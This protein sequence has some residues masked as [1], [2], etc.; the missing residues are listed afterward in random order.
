MT[1]F[2]ELLNEWLSYMEVQ[3]KP[4]TY[5]CYLR[6]AKI[7]IEPYFSHIPAEQ[8]NQS[9]VAAFISE[10]LE[11]GRSD[12]Q[13]GLSEKTVKDIMSVINSVCKYG[14][15]VYGVK[16]QPL[17][18]WRYSNISKPIQVFT[19]EEQK[20]LEDFLT[21]NITPHKLGILICLYTGMRLGE[22]CALSW[23]NV[24]LERKVFH[25]EKT[26][27]RIYTKEMNGTHIII[28]LPKSRAAIRE[29]P[30]ASCLWQYLANPI[31]QPSPE[32]CVI[33]RQSRSFLDPRTYQWNYKSLLQHCGIPYRNFHALRHTFATRCIEQHMD[34]KSLSEILGHTNVNIT[35]NRYVHSS[36]ETKRNQL[37]KLCEPNP[38]DRL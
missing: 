6:L 8:I 23:Q 21:R 7:H 28:G 22:I 10:K 30:I 36:M 24:D 35:L 27:Q 26:V 18:R 19:R 15:A 12:G 16:Q 25:I 1:N 4:S 29:I 13:G 3:V 2:V 34:V 20:I 9:V 32:G 38:C 17:M 5:A 33:D 14:A 31:T 37:E 11:N